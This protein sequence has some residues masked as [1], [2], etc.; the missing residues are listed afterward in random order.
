MKFIRYISALL[1]ILLSPASVVADVKGTV[2]WYM[3][4]EAGNDPYRVRYIVTGDYLR[5]DEGE[6]EGGW[7]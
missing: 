7:M 5:S 1:L 6:N 2:L 4:Q 3:E